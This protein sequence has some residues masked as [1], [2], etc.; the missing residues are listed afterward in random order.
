M[1][2][3][4]AIIDLLSQFPVRSRLNIIPNTLSN[5]TDML[6]N[7]NGT[8]KNITEDV[9]FQAIWDACQ[10]EDLNV[11]Y[12]HMKGITAVDN[13]LKKGNA[14]KFVIYQNWRHFLNWGTL[15]NW[16]VLH[17]SL[18]THDVAGV[19][20]RVVPEPHFSG[21]YGRYIRSLPTPKSKE[22]WV[23]LQ[24]DT[25]DSWLKTAPERFNDEY[26]ITS[27]PHKVYCPYSPVK[28]PAF[29]NLPR[30]EYEGEL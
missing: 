20:Y 15:E 30:I 19:N 24:A 17:E 22:W 18:R 14:Q 11:L 23:K 1:N 29:E 4:S 2:F 6:A 8:G 3:V 27:I 21:G 25:K 12:F 26:W 5:D 9:T 13:L 10:V 7:R 28:N 16:R